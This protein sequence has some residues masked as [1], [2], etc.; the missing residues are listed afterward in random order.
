[1]KDL[2]VA[3]TSGEILKNVSFTGSLDC[4]VVLQ[5]DLRVENLKG[6]VRAD[7]GLY[8]LKPA[9]MDVFG[10]RG[11]GDITADKSEAGVVYRINLTVSE[12]DF[13]RL[14][15]F[16]GAKKIIGGKGDLSV[17]L[18][19][20]EKGGRTILTNLDGTFSLRGDHLVTYTVDLDK[21][22]SKYETS[23]RFGLVDL[24]A[25]FIAGP[26]GTAALKGYRYGGIYYETQGGQGTI[27]QFV[28][29]WKIKNGEAEAMDC[30]FATS[31]HRVAIKGK[32]DLVSERYDNV[33]VALLD[34]KGCAVLKQGITG[35][36]GSPEIG[37]VRAIES[38]AGQVF[39]L[40]RKAKRFVQAD[41][42]EVFYNGSVRQP[43]R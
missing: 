27:T 33:V 18:T 5:E 41:R 26:L 35:S 39:D 4:K 13:E 23:Q 8:S 29:H 10:G 12:V 43:P 40:Y 6:S 9:T 21:I 22:L 25:F 20:K 34:D 24:G 37:A 16:S 14:V 31:H 42:Y 11:G 3:D 28:S 17:S 36:F 32:L 15:E 30:A 2:S 7:K 1:V 38:L 19:V